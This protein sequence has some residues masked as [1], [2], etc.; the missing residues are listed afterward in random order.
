M[1]LLWALP[2]LVLVTGTA[3]AGVLLDRLADDLARLDRSLRRA[4]RVAVAADG[5]VAEV[6]RLHGT[7]AGLAD[8]VADPGSGL[9]PPPGADRRIGPA[10]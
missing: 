10:R 7:A 5:L 4:G 8:R 1:P 9:R 6:G 2:V 3:V